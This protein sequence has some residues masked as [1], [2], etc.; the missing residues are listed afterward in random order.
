M[1]EVDDAIKILADQIASREWAD[2]NST[3]KTKQVNALKLLL[4][5]KLL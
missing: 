5:V 2:F 1:K 3:F 4:D